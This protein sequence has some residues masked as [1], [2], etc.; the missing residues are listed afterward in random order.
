MKLSDE[1]KI[2]VL[3]KLNNGDIKNK[4]IYKAL[5]NIL[6]EKRLKRANSIKD[7]NRNTNKNNNNND[8]N[9]NEEIKKKRN[10]SSIILFKKKTYLK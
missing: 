3:T 8:N 2:A 5:I 7:N 1:E 10:N 9:A 6:K 4:K